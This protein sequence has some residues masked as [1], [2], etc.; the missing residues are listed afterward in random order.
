MW[1]VARELPPTLSTGK[2]KGYNSVQ[3]VAMHLRV[4]CGLRNS[5]QVHTTLAV[6]I[7]HFRTHA[8]S[9]LLFT[10]MSFGGDDKPLRRQ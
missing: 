3:M 1:T 7:F 5:L 6:D 8:L 4:D 9:I 2:F 10:F